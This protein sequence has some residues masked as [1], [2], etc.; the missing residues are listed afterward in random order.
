M[1]MVTLSLEVHYIPIKKL[2]MLFTKVLSNI[3][4]HKDD[5]KST[6]INPISLFSDVFLAKLPHDNLLRYGE[7]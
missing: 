5:T 2:T 1:K 6:Y 3:F 7:L 4:Y